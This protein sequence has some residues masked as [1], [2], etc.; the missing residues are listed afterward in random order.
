MRYL[1]T[2]T[3]LVDKIYELIKDKSIDNE[4]YTFCDA[5]SGTGA[6]GGFLKDKFRIIANDVQ[7]YSFIISQ[8]KLNTPDLKFSKLGVNPFDYF[9]KEK[10]EYEGFVYKNYADQGSERMYFSAENGL[11]IDFIRNKIDEWKKQGKLTDFEYYYLIAALLESVSKVA[12]IAGVYGSY[13]KT[14]DPRA[15]KLMQ[16]IKVEQRGI[17]G[18]FEAEVHNKTIEELVNEL[19]GDILYL[20]P[21]YTNN[22]Y[23]VQYHLLETIAK[24][25]NPEIK[26]KGGLRNTSETA[27]AFSRKGDVET[28]FE[29]IIAKARFKYIILSYSSD[30]LMSQKYIENILKRYGKSETYE[31]RKINYKKYKNHQTVENQEH[32]EYLFF[33]EKKDYSEVKYASPLNY[34]GGKYDLVDFIQNNLPSE[35]VKRFIDAFGGGYSVGIN[36]EAEQIVYNEYNH[37]VVELMECFRNTETNDLVKYILK[38]Q[39]KYKLEPGNKEAYMKLRTRYNSTLLELRDPK[40]LYMLILYGFNQQIRF[41]SSYNCNNPVG[42]AGLNDNIIDK[43]SSFCRRIQEQNVIFFSKDFEKINEYVN[44]ETFVYCDPPYLITLGSYNDGKRGFNGWKT[45]DE[46]RLY[47]FL[48][49][50]NAK[51]VKFMMS[52]VLEHKHKKNVLLADWIK[53]NRYKIIKYDKY[54]RKGRKEVLVV[55]YNK[56]II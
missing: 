1:G 23:S 40:M 39:R 31:L 21:P 56:E 34:Q 18:L 32:C 33:I 44:D 8:A 11:K 26:G 27:S 16:F 47:N 48:D 50:L 15:V 13:L 55:N 52:N 51:G 41:N 20:D 4:N 45:S 38:T 12:N 17:K 24:N 5:F 19:S 28:V 43:I 53:K 37:K 49:N 46:L 10:L 14:W 22:Q 3:E 35:G 30:G 6:V 29:K 25:D 7:Y 42:P 2:K 54:A 36:I 9:N